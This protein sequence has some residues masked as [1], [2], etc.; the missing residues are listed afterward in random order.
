MGVEV[1]GELCGLTTRQALES[2]VTHRPSAE[3]LERG[4]GSIL[5]VGSA[6]R[7]I[8]LQA[9]QAPLSGGSS[10]NTESDW[11]S[12][13]AGVEDVMD[14]APFVVQASTPVLHAHMLFSRCGLRHVVVVD[15]AHRPIGVLTRKSLMP[16][17]T[18]WL[19]HEMAD[20]DTFVETRVAHSPLASPRPSPPRSPVAPR[21]A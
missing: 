20:S 16:W 19:D 18:P 6:P 4:D 11:G 9:N 12:Q 5:S 15:G 8:S 2:L 1:G 7:S 21:S 14:I 3:S 13:L 10:Q 17:R